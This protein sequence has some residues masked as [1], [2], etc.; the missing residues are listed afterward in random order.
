ML[1]IID[2]RQSCAI[3]NEYETS[4]IAD[5]TNDEEKNEIQDNVEDQS[6]FREW[7]QVLQLRSFNDELLTILPYVVLE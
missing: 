6:E 3:N 2:N 5:E 1:I 4:T 7:H